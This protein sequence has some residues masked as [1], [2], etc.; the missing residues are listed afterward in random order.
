[1]LR[2]NRYS[3]DTMLF[4]PADTG[5]AS[6]LKDYPNCSGWPGCTPGTFDYHYHILLGWMTGSSTVGWNSTLNPKMCKL[7][8]TYKHHATSCSQSLWPSSI[9][10]AF[11]AQVH[12]SS[13]TFETWYVTSSMKI[14]FKSLSMRIARAVFVDLGLRAASDSGQSPSFVAVPHVC[15]LSFLL[16]S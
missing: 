11:G 15:M 6:Y 10:N 2:R 5:A 7:Q 3:A 4:A 14:S 13:D 12:S 8:P 16:G 1:M 9:I